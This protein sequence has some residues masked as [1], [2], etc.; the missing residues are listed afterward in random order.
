MTLPKGKFSQSHMQ[1]KCLD[2]MS[3][4]YCQKSCLYHV[5]RTPYFLKSLHLNAVLKVKI[6]ATSHSV[7]FSLDCVFHIM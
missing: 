2:A 5:G 7:N 6:R 4:N 1:I 3:Y